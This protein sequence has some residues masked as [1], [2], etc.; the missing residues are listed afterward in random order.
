M[1]GDAAH[2]CDPFNVSDIARAL[3]DVCSDPD[4]RA[5]LSAAGIE[6]SKRYTWHHAATA[7]W[8]SFERMAKDAGLHLEQP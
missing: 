5:T 3:H 7:L 8:A 2:Y 1:A 6:R 4:L